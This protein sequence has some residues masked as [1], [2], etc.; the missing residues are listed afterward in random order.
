MA[1]YAHAGRGSLLRLRVG[2][3]ATCVASAGLVE[4]IWVLRKLESLCIACLPPTRVRIV[5]LGSG[6]GPMGCPDLI[7][8]GTAAQNEGGGTAHSPNQ[9]SV[10]PLTWGQA[11][12]DCTACYSLGAPLRGGSR[13]MVATLR[14]S[15]VFTGY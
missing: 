14:R 13:A 7:E 15:S 9:T 10:L 6:Q 11:S 2:S 8:A 12:T 1:C 3:I 4:L 5:L